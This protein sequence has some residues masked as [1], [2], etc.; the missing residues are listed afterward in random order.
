M[1]ASP[2]RMP[3]PESTVTT[4][5]STGST[6]QRRLRAQATRLVAYLGDAGEGGQVLSRVVPAEEQLATGRQARANVGLRPAPI[7][8]CI[9]DRE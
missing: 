3:R 4:A 8:M 1:P 6:L 7:E 2:T 5:R 9:R